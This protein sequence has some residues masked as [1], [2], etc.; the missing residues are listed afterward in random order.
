MKK[1]FSF[2]ALLFTLFFSLLFFNLLFFSVAKANEDFIDDLEYGKKLYENPRGISC[3]QCHGERGE[4]KIIAT[5]KSKGKVK[6]LLSPQINNLSL[7]KM[8]EEVNKSNGIMPKYHLTEKEIL[9]IY[10]FLKNQFN[11]EQKNN[12]QKNNNQKNNKAKK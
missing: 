1:H 8:M 7:K 3:R 11:E 4:G 12:N 6:Q 10:K 5:Y 2:L 9:A